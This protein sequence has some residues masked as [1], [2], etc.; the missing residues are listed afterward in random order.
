MTVK[1]LTPPNLMIVMGVSGSG[2]STIAKALAKSLNHKYLDADDYHPSSNINKMSRGEALNDEDRWPWLKEFGQEMT[3][4]N[5]P[6]VG[7]CSSLKR[8]YRDCITTSA[9]QPV[10]FIYLDGSK[11]LLSNRLSQR[12]NHFM[13]TVLLESQLNTLE[14]PEKSEYAITVDITGTPDEIVEKIKEKILT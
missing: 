2:K 14:I 12:E 13:P 3:K 6:C 8:S 9:E 11:E 4:Q 1:E 5:Q 7:A 10:L